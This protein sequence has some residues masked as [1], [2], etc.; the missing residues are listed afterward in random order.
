MYLIDTNVLAEA[1]RRP[2]PAR[3]WMRSVERQLAYVSVVTLG[4]IQKGIELTARRDA[5]QAQAL[6]DWLASIRQVHKDRVLPV[7]DEIALE[8]GRLEAQRPRGPDGFIAA[9]A[10][11]RGLALVTRNIVD[12]Q[13]VP[14]EIVD[15]WNIPWQ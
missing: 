12:F 1:R 3:S 4:E 11:V 2:G 5:Q 10:V 9:T 6:L 8:W 15:P 14:V 7:S 13:D